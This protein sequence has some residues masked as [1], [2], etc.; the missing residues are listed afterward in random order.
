MTP[1]A[2]VGFFRRQVQAAIGWEHS[3]QMLPESVENTSRELFK[4]HRP[5]LFVHAWDFKCAASV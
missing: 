5:I 2:A 1:S 3:E 4:Q